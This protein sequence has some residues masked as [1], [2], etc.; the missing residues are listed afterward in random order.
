MEVMVD[1]LAAVQGE[2]R[3]ASVVLRDYALMGLGGC[4]CSLRELHQQ[5]LKREQA[6]ERP[7]S[8]RLSTLEEWSRAFRW[9][10]QVRA[11]D[12]EVKGMNYFTDYDALRCV[13]Q[14]L[15]RRLR[16]APEEFTT[17]ELVAL[18]EALI[19]RIEQV[20]AEKEPS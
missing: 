3:S 19:G 2:T 4:R 1:P 17:P 8:V 13:Q 12:N 11:W 5:Y 9:Q 16:D 15:A 10:E 20:P 7:P 6:G 18:A 14:E